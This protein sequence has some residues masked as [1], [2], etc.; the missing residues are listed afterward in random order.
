M[1]KYI[2]LPAWGRVPPIFGIRI[3]R[4]QCIWKYFYL[5]LH[6]LLYM[7]ISRFSGFRISIREDLSLQK[8]LI[9]L[10]LITQNLALK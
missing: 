2:Y 3:R 1:T 8:Y 9:C 5:T 7:G 10:A 6:H 4:V